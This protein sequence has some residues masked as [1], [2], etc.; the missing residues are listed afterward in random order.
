VASSIS[1]APL[2]FSSAPFNPDDFPASQLPPNS[3]LPPSVVTPTE[4]DADK[5]VRV[6]YEDPIQRERQ[7]RLKEM[8]T[9]KVEPRK[10][11][12]HVDDARMQADSEPVPP[13]TARGRKGKGRAKRSDA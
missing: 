1:P 2:D 11:T 12:N 4:D 13:K 10:E 5:G 3:Q 8:L 9:G 7:R 6:T